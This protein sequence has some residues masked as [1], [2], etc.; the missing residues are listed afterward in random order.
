GATAGADAGSGC[1]AVGAVARGSAAGAG[2]SGGSGGGGGS[3]AGAGGG[4]AGGGDSTTGEGGG[5]GSTT[6]AGAGAGSGAG[7][8]STAGVGAS[9][10]R[11]I[12]AAS[13]SPR[14]MRPPAPV[15]VTSS[16]SS[17]CSARSRRTTGDK[18][19]DR[20]TRTTAPYP[21]RVCVSCAQ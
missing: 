1:S 12:T 21:V 5:G 18:K 15:P 14:V 10:L 19:P 6:A 9:P 4:A 2:A 13:T 7:A 20:E 17:D 16:G 11:A 3:T 8:A